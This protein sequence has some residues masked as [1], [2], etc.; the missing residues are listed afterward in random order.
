M[1]ADGRFRI[2]LLVGIAAGVCGYAVWSLSRPVVP[3]CQH[4]I[5]FHVHGDKLVN[6]YG[7]CG[8]DGCTHTYINAR[9]E[10]TGECG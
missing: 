9:G 1:K 3:P 8:H 10:D 7:P 4:L 5:G 6:V 2:Y